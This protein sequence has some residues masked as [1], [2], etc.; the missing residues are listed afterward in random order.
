MDD[1][2]LADVSSKQ[3]IRNWKGRLVWPPILFISAIHAMAPFAFFYISKLNLVAFLLSHFL[4]GGLGAVIGLHRYFSHKSFKCS[5]FFENI[6]GFLGTLNFQNGPITW[7]MYHRAHHRFSEQPGDPHSAHRGF[8]WSHIQWMFYICPNNFRKNTVSVK[9]LSSSRFLRFLDRHHVAVN[10]ITGLL[11][12]VATR[13]FGLFLWVFPLRLVVV[14]HSTWL[15]NS[16][17]HRARFDS[18]PLPDAGIRNSPLLSIMMYGD[19]WHRNHHEKPGIPRAGLSFGQFDP[20]YWL[21]VIFDLIGIVELRKPNIA[22][23]TTSLEQR[24]H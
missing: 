1:K 7:A 8:I 3:I 10:V 4:V 18:G 12:L 14:W 19:G 24:K 20:A 13:D 23:E 9:D 22:H 16:Y 15:I 21:L 5:K 17:I 6:I 2:I 11:F